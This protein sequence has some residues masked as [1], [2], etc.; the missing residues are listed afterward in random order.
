VILGAALCGWEGAP[1]L[2]PSGA[3]EIVCGLLAV[4]ALALSGALVASR[5]RGRIHAVRS[6]ALE[7]TGDGVLVVDR[8]G[9]VVEM[10][11]AARTV[12]ELAEQESAPPSGAPG[13]FPA[14]TFTKLLAATERERA[15]F[16][17]PS[18]R[19]IEAWASP[20]ASSAPGLR[21]L[22]LRDVTRRRRQ[23]RRLLQL[24]HF[25]SLTGLANRRFFL[26][27]LEHAMSDANQRDGTIALLYLDLDRFKEVNDS[28]GHA[29]GDE[30]LRVLAHRLRDGMRSGD[31]V[32]VGVAGASA[33]GVSRLAGDEF[34]VVIPDFGATG[35]IEAIA[36][37]ILGL[38]TQPIPLGA[39]TVTCS[40]SV[41]IA[42][43]PRDGTDV[44]SLF[45]CADAALYAA[46]RLGRNRFAFYDASLGHEEDRARRIAEELPSA[47]ERGELALHYQ[48]KIDLAS[49]TV[50]GLEALLRWTSPALGSISPKEFIPIAEVRGLITPIGSWCI[51]EACRQIRAWIDEGST[52]VTVAVNVSSAQFGENDLRASV[53]E[54]LR[55]ANIEP[56]LIELE[57][58]ESLFLEDAE[59]TALCLRDLRSIGVRLALDDFG[60]G[61]SSLSYL[62]RLQLDTL[63]MDRGFVRDVHLDDSAAEI[64]AA[65]VVMAQRLKLTV[66]AEGV[67]SEEQLERLI[68]MGCDQVQGFLFAPALPPAEAARFLARAGL[69][70]PAVPPSLQSSPGARRT[71]SADSASSGVPS[72]ARATEPGRVLVLDDRASSLASLAMR[73]LRLGVDVHYAVDADEARLF[74][75]QERARIRLL[76]APP[77]L[78]PGSIAAVAEHLGEVLQ[79]IAPQILVIG[80]EPDAQTREAVRQSGATWV[81]W[82]P[83]GDTE[84]RFLTRAAMARPE[85]LAHRKIPRVPV[86]LGAWVRRMG[87]RR[88][89]VI[90]DLSARGAYVEIAAPPPVGT[91]LRVEFELD[92]RRH[93]IF[94]RVVHSSEENGDHHAWGR[95]G[96]GV[97]F[98]DL[99]E[100]S[101]T[102]LQ[103][104]V[105]RRASRYLP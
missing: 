72:G 104:A 83:F 21:T 18:K 103:E 92:R 89:G 105:E 5:R 101:A 78:A 49:R 39:R 86:D 26:D 14:L 67:D 47:L 36:H 98:E 61:Y 11:A 94:G 62:N 102:A 37:R 2:G 82:T 44:E 65:V 32:G 97:V 88:A 64:A 84:L 31:L 55:E 87:E 50:V 77:S 7:A 19:V 10:N 59:D 51:R 56:R 22:V 29:A 74:I 96:F 66:V 91:W 58:T 42:L 25:D 52:P 30:L 12:L 100:D 48:P 34:A 38:M 4:A 45:K 90:T 28:L 70:A 53:T 75:A 6:A 68:G 57:L 27:R 8:R 40:G 33:A 46:K 95:S 79:R 76:I 81:L 41:G 3:L 85:E 35:E 23:E 80:D 69:P 43:F 20:V 16:E 93:R 73:L 1:P 54:A 63:K 99:D 15:L 13:V 9:R 24:A 17:T 71:G 60:T